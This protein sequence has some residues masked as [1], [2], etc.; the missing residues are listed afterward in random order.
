MVWAVDLDG[1]KLDALRAISGSS[2]ETG[3]NS[4]FSL[5]DLKYLFPSE[6]LPSSDS[7]PSYGLVTFGSGG[8]L[9][10]VSPASGPF[11]FFL[12]AGDSHVVTNLKKRNGEPEPF[13]FL[14]CPSNVR[15]QPKHKVQSARVACLSEDLDGCFR[16]L[17]HGV[18]G[19]IVE[20]PDNVGL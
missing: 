2:G 20:M 7:Q 5:V 4:A 19:T 6:D 12:V 8:D 14:D 15:D 13:T 3:A 18:E 1:S 16:I 10:D 11:G 9:H 17:E